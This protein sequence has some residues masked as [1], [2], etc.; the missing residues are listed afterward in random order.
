MRKRSISVIAMIILASALTAAAMAADPFVGTWKLNLDK[1]SPDMAYKS[2][3]VKI[4]ALDNGLHMVAD[5]VG[6]DGKDV[7]YEQT[8]IFDGKDY[9]DPSNPRVAM[10]CTRVDANT[11]IA[12]IKRDGKE[13][14]RSFDVV[15]QDGKTLTRTAM[16]KNTKGEDVNNNAVFDKQ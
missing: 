13:V 14:A 8:E 15:S 6:A 3:T 1:S 7:H 11:A 12:V 2:A 9:P 4:E 5:G 16:G 10:A